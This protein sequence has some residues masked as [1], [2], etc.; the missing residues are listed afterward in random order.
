MRKCN[1]ALIFSSLILNSINGFSQD[2][3]IDNTFGSSGIVHWNVGGIQSTAY[4]MIVLSNQKIVLVGYAVNSSTYIDNFAVARLEP[5]GSLDLSFGDNGISLISFGTVKDHANAV[6]EYPDGKLLVAGMTEGPTWGDMNSCMVRLNEDGTIDNSFGTSG[7]VIV[8]FSGSEDFISEIILQEDGKIITG[9][10]DYISYDQRDFALMRFNPDG[11]LD[12][13]FGTNGKVSTDFSN[14]DNELLDLAL[15]HDGSIY[16]VGRGNSSLLSPF[17][18]IAVSKYNNSGDLD[19]TFDTDGKLLTA[20]G[21]LGAV[22]N[23]LAVGSDGK[24]LISGMVKKS[25]TDLNLLVVRLNEDGSLD[26]SFGASGIIDYSAGLNLNESGEELIITPENKVLIAG[27]ISYTDVYPDVFVLKLKGN[28]T[29]DNS[30]GIDG[31][32][33][34]DFSL[35]LGDELFN[36]IELQQDGKIVAAGYGGDAS[37]FIIARYLNTIIDVSGIIEVDKISLYPNPTAEVMHLN[38]FQGDDLVTFNIFSINGKLIKSFGKLNNESTVDV[39][40]LEPGT[41]IFEVVTTS[42]AYRVKFIKN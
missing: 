25:S 37:E 16:A 21:L 24:I 33:I 27:Y 42:Q 34:S 22:G 4:D 14:S 6:F 41:Y 20:W 3:Q 28:G 9:G 35:N 1:Y 19:L 36:S 10:S 5:N 11:I 40:D 26:N 18:Q 7:K 31:I 32:V 39:K 30:F 23:S 15:H 38:N 8:D 29:L 13:S 17:L 12:D 2:G